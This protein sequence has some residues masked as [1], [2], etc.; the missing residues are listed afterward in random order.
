MEK[1]IIEKDIPILY[2][3]AN[4]F[5]DGILAAFEKL[6]VH[7]P[8]SM[9]REFYGLSR[10]EYDMNL[11]IVYKAAAELKT[12]D[13]PK[14]FGLNTM[15]ISKGTYITETVYNFKNDITLIG[16]AFD[17]LRQHPDLD[18]QGYCV[19]W[20]LSNDK[21]VVCMVPILE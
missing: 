14:K 6:H 15:V 7:L 2:V 16:K 20:Y 11:D 10:P 1:R 13:E 8:F 21:D 5:P 4:S 9:E 3:N 12:P 18:P 17:K 19:E